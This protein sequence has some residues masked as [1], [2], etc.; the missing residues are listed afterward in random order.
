MAL[1]FSTKAQTA[2]GGGM[3]MT[4][5]FE[6][7]DLNFDDPYADSGLTS[8]SS[9]GGSRIPRS[10]YDAM[11]KARLASA[12][13][14]QTKFEA[15]QAAAAA[16]AERL[17]QGQ[18]AQA[19][20]L[21]SQLG[22]GIPSTITGEIGAQEKAGQ[23]YIQSQYQ[24]LL[25]ALGQRR[26]VGERQIGTGYDALQT[27]LRQNP[28]VAYAQAQRAMPTVAQSDLTQYMAS[29][30]ISAEPTQQ[31]LQALNAQLTG[32]AANYNQ[33]L[34]V[35]TAAEQQQ[36][37]SRLA[38]EQMARQT[39][40]TQLGQLYA[41]AT[42]GLEQQRL[43]ALNELASRIS[44]ARLQAQQQQAAREQALQDALA[45]LLGQGYVK[46]GGTSGTGTGTGT[47]TITPTAAAQTLDAITAGS[48]PN[49]GVDALLE[50]I[51]QAQQSPTY[52]GGG[53]GGGGLPIGNAMVA[54]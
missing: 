24:N 50:L 4:S 44:A 15:E 13:L 51:A 22:A 35:L 43:A 32:G 29:R 17:R 49:P 20:Y 25:S 31:A 3:P 11:G 16:A 28:A 54:F 42:S 36:Q 19:A 34:N 23:E 48:T 38:E 10:Y 1:T 6:E 41:G 9:S 8:T 46:P 27:Y 12:G 21:R 53:G 14:A 39:G 45:A 26:E 7:I 30:G 40:L 33:L 52:S 2:L 47:G 5:D 18:E 37:G